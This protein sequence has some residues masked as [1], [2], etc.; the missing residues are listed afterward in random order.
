LHRDDKPGALIPFAGCLT[1]ESSARVRSVLLGI[2]DD[3]QS[4]YR[5]GCSRAPGVVRA[6]YD[7]RSFNSTTESGVN[8]ARS[9]LDLGDLEPGESW[10]ASALVYRAT[11]ERI[12]KEGRTPFV[13]AASLG[14]VLSGS[15]GVPT[16]DS[17]VR[18]T[19]RS[20]RGVRGHQVVSRLRG[21]APLRWSS[22]LTQ[23]GIRTPTTSSPSRSSVS[24]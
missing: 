5:W 2:A 16:T 13:M 14:D 18:P 9:V 6:A 12:L 23:L 21:C 22:I 1:T 17:R 19:P 20:V 8:L 7:G 4:S 10:S 24:R 3:R 11:V 15:V